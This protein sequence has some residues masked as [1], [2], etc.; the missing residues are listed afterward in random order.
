MHSKSLN[1]LANHLLFMMLVL[2]LSMCRSAQDENKE[3]AVLVPEELDQASGL[4]IKQIKRVY[5][6][7][8]SP[9]EMLSMMKGKDI[10]FNQRLLNSLSNYEY[11]NNTRVQALNLGIYL[12]DLAYASMF[13]RHE[14]AV[15]YLEIIQKLADDVRIHG[16]VNESL[17]NQT[18]DNIHNLDSLLAI[19]NEAFVNMVQLCE[20]SGKSNTLVLITSGVLV[21]SLYLA[22]SHVE[23]SA[24]A[25]GLFQHLADQKYSMDNLFSLAKSLSDDPYVATAITDLEPLEEFYS[26]L[27][28]SSGSTTVKKEGDGKLIIGGGNQ[29]ILTQEEFVRLRKTVLD[30]RNDIVSKYI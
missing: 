26:K 22:S 27:E 29:P 23:N 4:K 10:V 25:E 13:N 15:D 17:M 19:S 24:D 18:K 7:I 3:G 21:E 11:Y 5:H 28:R 20:E 30:I 16:A 8:P 2:L 6:S 14:I 1:S 9:A 12:A